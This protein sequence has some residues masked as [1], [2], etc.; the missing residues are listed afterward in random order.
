M[1]FKKYNPLPTYMT[2][3][4]LV[5]D[6]AT[7]EAILIDPAAQSNEILQDIKNLKLTMKFIVNTHGHGDHI[8]G[9]NY[10][11]KNLQ[12]PL[13]IHKLDAEMLTNPH[14]NLSADMGTEVISPAA[15][16]LLVDKDVV[17]FGEIEMK[18]IHT[19]GHTKGGICLYHEPY[20]FCGDTL[21]EESIGR[22]DLPG[23]NLEEIKKSIIDKLFKL[24]DE[25]K[26]F[27]GHGDFTSIE[28]EKIGNPFV[29]LVG[30]INN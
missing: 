30:K 2:N 28:D 10:F 13:C 15:D 7:L 19:P 22:T 9:N 27:P 25:T 3:T 17:S 4:Y 24:P 21:F 6:E 26:V 23:G 16:K 20:L 14:K 8:A 1:K 11:K 12:I 18:I 29:G 5:W